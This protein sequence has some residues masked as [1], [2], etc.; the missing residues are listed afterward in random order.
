MA[1]NTRGQFVRTGHLSMKISKQL[2]EIAREAEVRV[3][4]IVRDE[5]ERILREEVY[6]SYQPVTQK[7]KDTQ[8][9]N[10]NHAH[11]K[12]RPYHHT[13]ILASN[14]YGAIEG[15][16]IKLKVRETA[17]YD[18]GK[19]AAEVYDFLKYGTTNAPKK[20]SYSYNNG[21]DFSQYISQPPHNFE[22]RASERIN[23][24][25]DEFAQKINTEVWQRQYGIDR[26]I[27]K[28]ARKNK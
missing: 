20:D 23:R 6:D 13:G 25:L 2:Q 5:A 19:S 14:I 8:Q 1:R 16:E 22:A 10:E 26:Y 11:Q 18:N 15:D 7:G 4:P 27:D 24:F 28:V 21:N 12:A 17:K 9:Y 3:K